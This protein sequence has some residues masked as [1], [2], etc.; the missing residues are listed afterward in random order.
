MENIKDYLCFIPLMGGGSYGRNSDR[1]QAIANAYKNLAM[2]FGSMFDIFEKDVEAY[3]ADVT[4]YD[5]I[6]FGNG[7]WTELDNDEKQYFE[8]EEIIVQLPEPR[9]NQRTSGDSYLKKVQAI[10]QAS[11]NETPQADTWDASKK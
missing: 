7:I 8:A 10:V 11:L 5:V 4:G 1:T 9:K 2:D 3:V 6:H